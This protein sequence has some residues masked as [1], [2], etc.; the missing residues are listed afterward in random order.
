MVCGARSHNPSF[1]PILQGRSP[2]ASDLAV[3]SIRSRVGTY[4][5][6]ST[7]THPL[8]IGPRVS[9]LVGVQRGRTAGRAV[10]GTIESPGSQRPCFLPASSR[11]C[12]PPG[13]GPPMVAPD[14]P[15]SGAVATR[16]LAIR[17]VRTGFLPPLARGHVLHPARPAP[18]QAGQP[19]LSAEE[20]HG[21]MPRPNA[22]NV[23]SRSRRRHI[24]PLP[25]P[26]F[27]RYT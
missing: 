12:S 2:S 21:M 6:R 7:A 26:R 17:W 20:Q 15:R 18:N 10:T 4:V 23:Q 1:L 25:Q 24:R 27:V 3:R 8:L 14:R 5:A 11:A 9:G 19:L 16:P 22:R 13:G